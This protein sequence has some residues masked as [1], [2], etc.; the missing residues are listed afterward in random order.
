VGG[1]LSARARE[2]VCA[3]FGEGAAVAQRIAGLADV[4]AVGD[5]QDVHLIAVG[6]PDHLLQEGVR[7][8]RVAGVWDQPDAYGDAV[9]VRIDWEDGHAEGEEQDA[10]GGFRADTFEVHEIVI[11]PLRGD[12][13]EE[14]EIDFSA[15]GLDVAEDVLDAR[16][17]D[18]AQAAGADGFFHVVEGRSH[19]LVPGGELFPEAAVCRGAVSIGGILRED[20]VDEDVD[21]GSPSAARSRAIHAA[22]EGQRAAHFR[23][24]LCGV[25]HEAGSIGMPASVSQSVN[26]GLAGGVYASVAGPG[27]VSG[28]SCVQA[29]VMSGGCAI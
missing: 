27:G 21:G 28:A 10:V 19:D 1:A 22:Q 13:L 7:C 12:V 6:R 11:G 23:P 20:G 9:D 8:F 14:L 18:A 2:C 24:Q 17:L 16:G 3:E 26:R 15:V 29:A 25:S 5:E 4:A